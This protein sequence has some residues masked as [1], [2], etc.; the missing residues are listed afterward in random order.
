MKTCANKDCPVPAENQ[1]FYW[2]K[3]SGRHFGKCME[4]H[5]TVARAY[6]HRNRTKILERVAN[7]NQIR[8]EMRT[9]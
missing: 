9:L 5:R 3:A 8:R 4:C 1:K 2:H 7:I 6:Y